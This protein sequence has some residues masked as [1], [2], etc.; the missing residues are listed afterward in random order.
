[1]DPK[2]VTADEAAT[3]NRYPHDFGHVLDMLRDGGKMARA[4]WNGKGMW[5]ALSPGFEL[6]QEHVYSGPVQ[7]DMGDNL[8]VFRPY[9]IMKTVD[10]EYVPWVASQTDLLAEDWQIVP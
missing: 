1:M 10:G 7:A 4:G 9:I 3:F 2:S 5:V 8:G 6:S